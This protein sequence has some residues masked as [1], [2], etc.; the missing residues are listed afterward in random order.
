[1]FQSIP[2]MLFKTI[3]KYPDKDAL[4]F[5]RGGKLRRFTYR[6]FGDVIMTLTHGLAAVGVAPGDKIAILS[7]NRPEWTMADFAGLSLRGVVVPIYQTLPPNQIAYIL[8]DSEARAIFVEDESQYDKIAQIRKKVRGLKYVFSFQPIPGAEGEV[9]S[10]DDVLAQGKAHQAQQPNFYYESIER[11]QP[12]EICS[13]VYTSGTTGD[14]KGVMLHHHGFITD[15][16]NADAVL[17]IEPTDVFLSFLPL[18]HLYE[19]LAGHWTPMYK[20]ATIHYSQSIDTV[21]DDIAEAKPSVIVSVPRLYEK[22]AARVL[23]QVEHGSALKQ[24]IFYWA[25]AVG[26][27]YHD[28]RIDGHISFKIRQQYK[29][30]NKLVFQ[31]I[32][33]K[34]GG[35]LRFPIA[36]GAPLAVETLK[37][38][39]SLD[40]QII[41]GYGM[42]ETHLII[43]LTPAG[44]SRYGS[45][46]KPIN[47]VQV[48]IASDG[49]VLIK[50][51]TVMAGYYKKPA[52]TQ[53]TIDKD[54]WLH[55]GDIGYLDEDNY[56][57]LTD[58]KKNILITSGGKNIASAPIE[59][60]LKASKYIDEVCLIGNNRK[61]V[62]A[63]IVPNY[64]NLRK[65]AQQ[66]GLEVT[67]NSAL[68]EQAAVKDFVWQEVERLQTDFARFEQVKKIALLPEP[69]TI[70]KGE[71]TPS[72][73]V[74]RN[75]VEQNY[76]D[77][78]DKIYLS[79]HVV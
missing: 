44:K 43:T 73:K 14:P 54:G 11:I 23:E 8:N 51:P 7:N 17:N 45:C 50:G 6:E 78:I 12:Q 1:M 32:K 69:F 20:G 10:F 55:T 41:E 68:V 46:G 66:H 5:R 65:W 15:I 56:L 79:E 2:H 37:F 57:Y 72:L 60:A 64:E 29:L 38:F 25:L 76:K 58:R 49:E 71:L 53:E 19:R 63:L 22:I 34:M 33:D 39:E 62:S 42:T 26:R 24:K 48:K 77:L 18:S 30:A 75:V 9:L 31:K 59:N 3:E 52:L 40:M 28:Q 21:I 36:G 16:V 27:K 35:R 61:F 70:E 4:R 74:K 67:E 13:M 47:Q